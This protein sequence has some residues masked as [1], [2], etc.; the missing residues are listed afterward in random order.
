[1]FDPAYYSITF[2]HSSS[3]SVILSSLCHTFSP[4][5]SLFIRFYFVYRHTNYSMSLSFFYP[6]YIVFRHTIFFYLPLDSILNSVTILS[7]LADP[8]VHSVTFHP[9][10]LS[11]QPYFIFHHTSTPFL[12]P[13]H[14]LQCILSHYFLPSISVRPYFVLRHLSFILPSLYPLYL[15]VT[16]RPATA[17]NQNPTAR[18]GLIF[19]R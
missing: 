8:T 10:T 12:D 18:K 5:S 1:M 19:L 13:F 14:T 9:S 2:F 7:S 11:I 15:I 3:L 16:S 4:P 17:C 6:S